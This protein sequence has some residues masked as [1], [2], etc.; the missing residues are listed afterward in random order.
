MIGRQRI[1][2]KGSS[3]VRRAEQGELES[4][5]VSAW[6]MVFFYFL[7]E[8]SQTERSTL[9]FYLSH[10]DRNTIKILYIVLH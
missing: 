9:M 5:G 10:I 1:L 6:R 4:W 2:D 8:R 7:L 3:T